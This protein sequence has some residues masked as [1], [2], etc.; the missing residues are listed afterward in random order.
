[1]LTFVG[2]A[3][4]PD[5]ARGVVVEAIFE[6]TDIRYGMNPGDRLLSWHCGPARTSRI[7]SPFD[8][9]ELWIERRG[10][11]GGATVEGE[12]AGRRAVWKLGEVA[13]GIKVRPD[14]AGEALSAY[15]VGR[16]LAEHG[17]IVQAVAVWNRIASDAIQ[18]TWLL[19]HSADALSDRHQW[20][21]ADA[22]YEQAV[23]VA[24]RSRPIV[25]AEVHYAWAESF[26][27]RSDWAHAETQYGA[28]LAEIS[29]RNGNGLAAERYIN[30]LGIVALRRGDLE[31]AEKLFA[32][33]LAIS[34]RLSPDSSD[35]PLNNLGSIAWSRGDLAQAQA[36]LSRSLAITAKATP[37]SMSFAKSLANF[38]SLLLKRSQLDEAEDYFRRSLEIV[39]RIDPGNAGLAIILQ[40]LGSLYVRR[41]DLDNAEATFHK[42]LNVK[43]IAAP[44]SLSL[45]TTL[46]SVAKV[47]QRLGRLSAA[48][49][50]GIESLSIRKRLAPGSL[51]VADS[52]QV[53]GDVSRDRGDLRRAAA[54]YRQALAITTR[55]ADGSAAQAEILGALGRLKA[56][57]GDVNAA[58]ILYNRAI[59]ALETQT[60]RLGASEDTR[61]EFRAD[62]SQLFAEYVDILL[63]QGCPELA[64]QV[65]ERSRAQVLLETLAAARVE[66]ETGLP[67]TL[68]TEMRTLR[69]T[70]RSRIDERMRLLTTKHDDHELAKVGDEITALLNQT[71]EVESRITGENAAYASLARPH[72]LSSSDVGRCLLDRETVLL[73]Y[74]LGERQGHAFVVTTSG[75]K[76]HTL[77]K[78]AFVEDLARRFY[79]T[80]TERGRAVN[81]ETHA[82]LTLRLATADRQLLRA[83]ADLSRILLMP[84]IREIEGK[85]LVIVSDGALQYIPFAALPDP[86]TLPDTVPCPLIVRHEIVSLPSASVLAAIREEGARRDTPRL[87]LAVIADPVFDDSDDRL[88]PP[89][90]PQPTNSSARFRFTRL[91]YARVEAEAILALNPGDREVAALD[92]DANRAVATGQQLK[93][94]K[95]VHFATHGVLDSAHPEMSGLALSMIESTGR[96]QDGFLGLRDIY[97]MNLPVELVVLSGCETGLGRDIRGEGVIG[98]TRGFIHAGA[99]RVVASLWNVSDA[100]TANLMELFYRE[101]LLDGKAPA[102]AIRYAQITLRTQKRW[103][104]PFYWAGF[105]L[106][107]EWR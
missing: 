103:S 2:V 66:L 102:E 16:E 50:D 65:L 39:N 1:V 24:G 64:F 36:Y 63:A 4:E 61:S 73:A 56:R 49:E 31:S 100:A 38:G 7:T 82:Q 18:W 81:D 47:E 15:L 52:L 92:F 60:R 35:I 10:C 78:R 21:E 41:G 89:V 99:L 67:E 57:E 12:R 32:R 96:Q 43:R 14:F 51:A 42:A 70:L 69:Q 19:T 27:S 71:A 44:G 17:K 75:I 28:A 34:D 37:G 104:A 88:L 22:A 55:L 46:G 6:R 20:K 8:F 101:M 33:E 91:P 26:L 13:S 53:I 74:S 86:R 105:Q 68:R 83:G 107:G 98:L 29:K 30:G 76:V 40:N 87:A 97:N 62:H 80:L 106:Y 45:A 59:A 95:I 9:A 84:T 72:V 58:S 79:R 5:R 90:R 25:P 77:P 94:Y 48:E 11:P 93:R 54:H 3:P 85:R 23:A